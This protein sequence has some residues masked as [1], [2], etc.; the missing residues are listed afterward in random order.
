MDCDPPGF[1]VHGVFQA[2]ILKYVA[3][4]YSRRSFE[5]RDWTQVSHTAGGFL[6]IWA[7]GKSLWATWGRPIDKKGFI[8]IKNICSVKDNTKRMIRQATDWE[9]IFAKGTSDKSLLTKIYKVQI[10]FNNKK[11][12]KK[13]V[14]NGT[15][16]LTVM[17]PRKTKRWQITIMKRCLWMF[18]ATLLIIGKLYFLL[19]VNG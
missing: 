5:P 7:T 19:E 15:K 11:T 9:K 4:S 10:K 14:K 1:S 3:I 12:N 2:R 6:T 13:S 17:S 18:I 16:T 8:C